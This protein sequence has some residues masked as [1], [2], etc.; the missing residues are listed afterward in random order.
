MDRTCTRF[1]T[2]QATVMLGNAFSAKE[3]LKRLG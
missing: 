1:D 2:G 3:R